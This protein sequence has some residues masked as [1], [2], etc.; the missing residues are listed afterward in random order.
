MS[1]AIEILHIGDWWINKW[2]NDYRHDVHL[3]LLQ[4]FR[5]VSWTRTMV[6]SRWHCN[7]HAEYYDSVH[8]GKHLPALVSDLSSAIVLGI[9]RSLR[10]R[11][12]W[13]ADDNREVSHGQQRLHHALL[14]SVYWLCR[15]FPEPSCDSYAK[16]KLINRSDHVD[17][18]LQV[19]LRTVRHPLRMQMLAYFQKK[20]Y[21]NNM[22]LQLYSLAF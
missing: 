13:H 7:E 12:L 18:F 19:H 11:Y 2:I 14:G 8:I 6:V 4:Y 17:Y 16:G 15:S 10:F 21:I 20:N 22:T 3:R 1:I 5:A 9:L